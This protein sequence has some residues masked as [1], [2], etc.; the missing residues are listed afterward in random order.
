[1]IFFRL[2]KDFKRSEAEVFDFLGFGKDL[3]RLGVEIFESV[4]V[5]EGFWNESP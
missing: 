3:G 4:S 5:L 1:M 2:G